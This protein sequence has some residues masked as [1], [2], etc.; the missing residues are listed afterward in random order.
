MRSPMV[1]LASVLLFAACDSNNGSGGTH[2]SV[3]VELAE[4]ADDECLNVQKYFQILR[5]MPGTPVRYMTTDFEATALKNNFVSP[6]FRRRSAYQSFFL[7]DT[8][9]SRVVEIRPLVQ[10]DCETLT[11]VAG[12]E[13]AEFRIVATGPDFLAVENDFDEKLTY[14]WLSPTSMQFVHEYGNGDLNCHDKSNAMLKVTREL[15]WGNPAIVRA[16]TL[17]LGR[18]S[19]RYINLLTQATGFP[20]AELYSGAAAG[21]DGGFM[22]GP[23]LIIAPPE[24]PAPN[25]P[26]P[27]EPIEPDDPPFQPGDDAK[28][29]VAK[30]REM[31]QQP[32]RPELLRCD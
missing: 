14:K 30:I 4:V 15:V 16:A 7:E 32:L 9:M 13:A 21:I 25:P 31:L 17:P 22:I 24:T 23:M 8:T 26:A 1:V 20:K 19:E 6:N 5:S 27:A 28:I 11:Y 18:I 3:N 29:S 2:R 12:S 10:R